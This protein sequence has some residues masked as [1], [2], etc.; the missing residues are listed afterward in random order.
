MRYSSGL[1][2]VIRLAL[3]DHVSCVA[4]QELDR[5]LIVYGAHVAYEY[6]SYSLLTE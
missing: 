6:V 1:N 4:C 2:T 3:M 5:G